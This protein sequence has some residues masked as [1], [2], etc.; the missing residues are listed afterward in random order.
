MSSHQT[1]SGPCGQPSC[2][3]Q[4][5]SNKPS[6]QGR[7][8][9][10]PATIL[11]QPGPP[12][13][14]FLKVNS[15]FLGFTQNTSQAGQTD[16]GKTSER[17]RRKT[18]KPCRS[19]QVTRP[20]SSLWFAQGEEDFSWM[21]RF[22]AHISSRAQGGGQRRQCP[23]TPTSPGKGGQTKHFRHPTA[24]RVSWGQGVPRS[25]SCG[26][27][28]QEAPACFL[29]FSGM[30]LPTSTGSRS[31]GLGEV[32]TIL[33]PAAPVIISNR[34]G[35]AEMSLHQVGA[36]VPPV[37]MKERAWKLPYSPEMAKALRLLQCP[38]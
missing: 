7:H 36:G 34:R 16:A 18:H 26:F 19:I 33:S 23:F 29:I 4:K 25:G 15:V 5:P 31:D 17:E 28:D 11:L 12:R 8:S 10:L 9:S 32:K 35:C 6:E 30:E 1:S 13:G 37:R 3:P 21:V 14:T 2:R 24:G 20:A 22:P 27:T 38:S